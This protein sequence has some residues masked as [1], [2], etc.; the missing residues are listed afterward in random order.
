MTSNQRKA[1]YYATANIECACLIAA[2][3]VKYPPG[4]LPA[5]WARLVLKPPAER[6][7]PAGGQRDH[8]EIC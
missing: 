4:S 5:I 6:T 3:P 7:A 2:D 1:E 8:Q